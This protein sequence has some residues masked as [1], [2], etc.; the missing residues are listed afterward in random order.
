MLGGQNSNSTKQTSVKL[1]FLFSIPSNRSYDLVNDGLASSSYCVLNPNFE[2]YNVKKLVNEILKRLV[3]LLILAV[4]PAAYSSEM[5]IKE[6]SKQRM[7]LK[8]YAGQTKNDTHSADLYDINTTDT[9]VGLGLGVK[10]QENFFIDGRIVSLGS[11]ETPD[12]TY[13]EDY[14]AITV[15]VMGKLPLGSGFDL[16]GSVGYGF[17]TWEYTLNSGFFAVKVRDTGDTITGGVGLQ[18][19]I[20]GLEGFSVALGYDTYYF[21]TGSVS[22]VGDEHSNTI[23]YTSLSIKYWF[24]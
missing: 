3:L 2:V 24:R 19:R 12:D 15:S 9:A 13:K 4:P 20:P 18:Y 16:Y 5:A 7:Y 17:I 14:R 6:K 10:I 11:Y 22:G 1:V 8:V 21:K 23:D